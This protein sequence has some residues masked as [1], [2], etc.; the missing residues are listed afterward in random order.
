MNGGGG[1]VPASGGDRILALQGPRLVAAARVD[2]TAVAAANLHAEITSP[3]RCSHLKTK[4][5]YRPDG[6]QK[7]G[8]GKGL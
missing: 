2:T 7:A 6:P 8:E 3:P 1:V 5:K 4:F